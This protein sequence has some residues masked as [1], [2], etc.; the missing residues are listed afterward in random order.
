[1]FGSIDKSKGL[2]FVTHDLELSLGSTM[3]KMRE[4]V[5]NSSSC[6]PIRG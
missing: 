1:M 5:A 4:E 3:R 6:S 2:L